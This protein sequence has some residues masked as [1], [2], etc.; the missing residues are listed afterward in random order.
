MKSLGVY[1][2]IP[3]CASKC[4]FCNFSSK[5]AP[6][7]ELDSYLSS[8]ER[9]IHLVAS[10]PRTSAGRG[11]LIGRDLLDLPVDSL[12]FGGGTPTLL[13]GDGLRRVCEA[14]RQHFRSADAPEF[15]LETTPGSAD[16]NLLAACRDLGVN[17][18]SIG[19]QSFDDRELASV[20]RLH[21]GNDV[22]RQVRLARHAGFENI[23]LDLIAG[24]PHQ[25]RSSWL[26]SLTRAIELE[27]EHVSIYLFEIDEK[28]R[29]GNEVLRHGDR[30]HASAVPDD[31][32][33]AAA[34][35]QG[36]ALLEAAG[37]VQYEISNFARPGFE[38]RH[39]RKYWQ[40][41]PYLGLGA[42]AHSFD[43]CARWSNTVL[44]GDYA[45]RV[46]RG[47]IPVTEW[48][49]LTESERI[50]EFFFLGLRQRIGIDL[51][52]A[53]ERWGH[54]AL[55]PWQSRIDVLVQMGVLQQSGG[56]LRLAPGH[57]LTSNEVFQEFLLSQ[58]SAGSPLAS[59][60]HS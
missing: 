14:L 38:S 17:R 24:L 58:D 49:A 3:F 52:A 28:S 46:S 30:Y 33:M 35:E 36:Q 56:P 8:L 25:T 6:Q 23:S 20:G 60:L 42:G 5:V 1:V 47:E 29:L 43:G 7:V 2:Q 27:P 12:Y 37:V 48:H 41:D 4:S 40:L 45:A 16:E 39:N 19:A 31:E 51:G 34:Y 26:M 18:L 53:R 10:R 50:E 21:S 15:T 54:A 11:R 55:E 13:G 22:E 59:A 44:T 32:F 9:E 57:Y